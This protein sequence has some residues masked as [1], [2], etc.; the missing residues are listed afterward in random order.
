MC[1]KE[2]RATQP[3][4]ASPLITAPN[5]APK[6]HSPPIS[7]EATT[8]N[9]LQSSIKR[10]ATPNILQTSIKRVSDSTRSVLA[11][12]SDAFD[13]IE[14]EAS[15]HPRRAKLIF[16]ADNEQSL[17][18]LFSVEKSMRSEKS[19]V[20]TSKLGPSDMRSLA[21]IAHNHMKP[22]M[23]MFVE[24]HAETLKRFR[25]TGTASTMAM[26]RT[27]FGEDDEV[28]YGA[29]CSSGPLG[30]DAQIA[31]LMCLED[32]GAVIFFTDP[33]SAHPHQADVDSLI[34]LINVHNVLH[35]TNPTSAEGLMHLL[36]TA[37][38]RNE[39]ERIPS[40]FF[41]IQSPAVPEYQAQ[42]AAVIQAASKIQTPEGEPSW[43]S[44]SGHS[45]HSSA[46]VPAPGTLRP[47]SAEKMSI[48]KHVFKQGTLK[49]L[50]ASSERSLTS[51]PEAE[52]GRSTP[53]ESGR[54][55]G[56]L[57]EE[58]ARVRESHTPSAGSTST[59]SPDAAP[60]G[61]KPKRRASKV[62]PKIGACIIG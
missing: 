27:V 6:V 20:G 48:A 1:A 57:D 11:F 43:A 39:P 41:T 49:Y 32:I 4:P 62:M 7:G 2:Q 51:V 30:G 9:I 56:S 19:E 60:G 50:S 5:A 58:V 3:R 22:A 29:V 35:A 45:R 55:R 24:E 12:T 36:K 23:R 33:L 44:H 15:R 18:S 47:S 37:V 52:P 59:P 54:Q 13:R 38:E 40:F 31:A 16:G 8:S 34:R 53:R 46:A 14:A 17:K 25:V 42:Q 10:E 21:L 61:G 28:V 26:L